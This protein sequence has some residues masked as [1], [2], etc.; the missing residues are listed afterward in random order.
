MANPRGFLE[1]NRENNYEIEPLNR[2]KNYEE[3]HIYLDE[4]K[5]KKQAA[6]CMNCGVPFCGF[7]DNIKGV[8]IGCPLHNLIPEW[9]TLVYKGLYDEA[10]KRLALT[11]PFP[12]FT[13]RVCPALC[14]VGCI[15][16]INGEATSI[17]ETEQFIIEK[18]FENNLV[19]PN[20]NIKRKKE[21]VCVI[22]SGPSGLAVANALNKKGY[23]VTVY[24]ASDHV[25]GLLMYGIPNMKLDKKIIDRRVNILKEE[26]IHFVTNTKVGEDI[27]SEDILRNYDAVVFSTG[28][29]MPRDIKIPGRELKGIMFAVDYLTHSTKTLIN[30]DLS[31]LSKDKNIIVIGGGDTGNDCVGTAIREQAR[32][33]V[34][35]E[36][37]NK[38]S[39]ERTNNWPEWPNALKVDYGA[40]EAI[41]VYG[42]DIRIFN[43]TAKEFVG[44]KKIEKVIANKVIW[45]NGK[46]IETNEKIE[47]NA[48]LV[49]LAMGFV[50]SDKL[51]LDRF[52]LDSDKR[53]NI[54]TDNYQTNNKKVFACGDA[55]TGQSLVVKAINSGIECANCVEKY[56]ESL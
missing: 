6:R 54:S 20:K 10:Y 42:K 28:S 30:G 13:S 3:F 25:G 8:T 26:G 21:K 34:Q 17:K 4:E 1:F 40:K 38:P 48:D 16:N 11:S 45:E 14:E 55:K 27:R 50:G 56:L 49:I 2:I 52:N 5:R 15:N 43:I 12:E 39:L 7:G 19:K 47:F 32:S 33:V 53:S 31:T 24:E 18:A 36:I 29:R 37:M 46:I 44:N 35:F 41:A 51:M 23:C 22:G 9:Q